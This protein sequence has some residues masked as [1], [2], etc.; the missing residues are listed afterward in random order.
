M[1]DSWPNGVVTESDNCKFLNLLFANAP[2]KDLTKSLPT[3]SW[4]HGIFKSC[5]L[6]F[7]RRI[8]DVN[9]LKMIEVSFNIFNDQ[10]K[11]EASNG[12]MSQAAH[13]I[14]DIQGS[15]KATRYYR[16]A[17]LNGNNCDCR[18]S[19]GG[20]DKW[21]KATCPRAANAHLHGQIFENCL[22][23][24]MK[25]NHEDLFPQWET[26]PHWL[27]SGT[28]HVLFNEYNHLEGTQSIFM[29]TG[30][31][32]TAFLIPFAHSHSKVL[33]FFWSSA[34]LGPRGKARRTKHP[35]FCCFRILAIVWS[36]LVTSSSSTSMLF[37]PDIN[38]L[39][40]AK[41]GS[42]RE[43]RFAVM[44]STGR[45]F[46][47]SWTTCRRIQNQPTRHGLCDGTALSGGIAITLAAAGM[48]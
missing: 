12:H 9:D 10:Q 6:T 45:S 34:S 47:I 36:C 29:M 33:E 25:K 26:L 8:H 11:W 15:K 17:T 19:F 37:L 5:F 41:G 30:Q 39:T 27:K 32:P 43:F 24:N 4:D 21:K 31:K 20:D 46:V 23:K 2:R 28:F 16:Q 7:V 35:F 18:I 13:R 22:M 44:T 42:T 40:S 38:G 14:H 3:W 48:L 1:T